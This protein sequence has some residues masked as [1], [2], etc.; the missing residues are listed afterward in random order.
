[1]N[2]TE[3]NEFGNSVNTKYR[4][5]ISPI[6]VPESKH[7]INQLR[8]YEPVSM[9]GQPEVVWDRA[10]GFNVYDR[11]GNKWIDFTSGVLVT[12]TG[13]GNETVS[14]AII[15]MVQHGL[16]HNYCFPSEIRADLVKKLS[17]MAPAPLK[18]VFLL[19][20][21]SET[22]E[23]AIKLARTYG[24]RKYGN[25]KKKIITFY[26][27]FH[28]RTMG[29]LMAG[30]LPPAK[31]WIINIDPDFN[32]VPFPNA[33]IHS[34]ADE[35]AADYSD[36]VCFSHF[37]NALKEQNIKSEHIAGIMSETYQG[38]WGQLMPNGF[39]K[40][41]RK[42]CDDNDIILILD[43]VQSGMGRTGKLFA[44]EHNNIVPDIICCGKGISSSLPLSAV[45]GRADIMDLYGPNEM[46]S[47]HT[48]NP[49][50]CAAA[51]A[52]LNYL[53]DNHLIEKT[54]SLGSICRTF[55][56]GLQEKYKDYIGCV[57]GIGLVWGILFVKKET[58]DGDNALAK[59][60]VSE[61]VQKG[62]LLFAPVGNGALIKICPPLVITEEALLEG[63]NTFDE[64]INEVVC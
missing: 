52:N 29:S 56:K 2:T 64:A 5:I 16:L 43:E 50:C 37:L 4:R 32:Q 47:T 12:N 41:L 33:Y 51:L 42:F 20:T 18:K 11:Y 31:S 36:E 40:L 8:E 21:G 30:G 49:V 22:A 45:I 6:P 28:G 46:T 24:T 10:K 14:K 25:H 19:S 38:G 34:W 9:S 1:M 15:G 13:H 26:D 63:L 35:N 27:A 55:F 7:I 17:D 54:F 61:A 53:F 39:A 59:K 60:I 57:N 62:L 23:C 48:G 58:R 3:K 44:F